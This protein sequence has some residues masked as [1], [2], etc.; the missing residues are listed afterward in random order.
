M[1]PEDK[2]TMIFQQTFYIKKGKLQKKNDA[3]IIPCSLSG[4]SYTNDFQPRIL[5]GKEKKALL[6]RMRDFSSGMNVKI[7]SSGKLK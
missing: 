4:V 3:K 1:D 6:S 5:K 7:K 2:D